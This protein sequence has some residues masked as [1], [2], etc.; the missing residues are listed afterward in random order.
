MSEEDQSKWM[1]RVAGSVVAALVVGLLGQGIMI[2]SQTQVT[3][4]RLKT[5]SNQLAEMKTQVSKM[6]ENGLDRWTRQDHA[7]YAEMVSTKWTK[8]ESAVHDL[9]R[10]LITIEAKVN[11]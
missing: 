1:T 3:N 7:T 2:Y 5:M 8:L 11:R 4:E 9:E 10:K 6:Q